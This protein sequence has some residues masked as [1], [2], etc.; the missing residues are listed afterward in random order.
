[1]ADDGPGSSSAY[2]GIHGHLEPRYG[3]IRELGDRV[4]DMPKTYDWYKQQMS[5]ARQFKAV[6][7]VVDSDIR[8]QPR[9]P[10]KRPML[11]ISHVAASH[12]HVMDTALVSNNGIVLQCAIDNYMAYL[13]ACFDFHQPDEDFDDDD[14]GF[15]H[16]GYAEVQHQNEA[17]AQAEDDGY[18]SPNP[19]MPPPAA[20]ETPPSPVGSATTS[21]LAERERYDRRERARPNDAPRMA[22]RHGSG[23][24]RIK[25]PRVV[26][27]TPPPSSQ[28]SN[29]AS[30]ATTLP[31]TQQTTQQIGDADPEHVVLVVPASPT[32]DTTRETVP[33]P[34]KLIRVDAAELLRP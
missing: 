6:C 30:L 15:R 34:P 22:R 9:W 23:H 25:R 28:E 1:M 10:W 26:P 4:W 13:E 29:A 3:Y 17:P 5:I 19:P 24:N 27:E 7:R 21:A 8:A 32:R 11:F 14:D 20:P 2:R 33:S 12:I 31:I 18:A 16:A